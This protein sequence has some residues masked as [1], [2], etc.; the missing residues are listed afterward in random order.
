MRCSKTPKL[1]KE[2][3]RSSVI[4]DFEGEGKRKGST[5]PPLPHMVGIFHP[6]KTGKS[7]KYEWVALRENWRPAVNGSI[8]M[9]NKAR[10]SDLEEVFL[11]IAESVTQSQGRIIHWSQHESD[12]LQAFLK[13]ATWKM[14]EPF[15]FNARIPAKRYARR[16]KIF[17]GSGEVLGKTLEEFF[18]ALYR[19]RNPFPPL[20]RGAAATCRL[21]DKACGSRKRWRNFTEAE[22]GYVSEL[23]EYN[24]GDCKTT[25]LITLKTVNAALS[26]LLS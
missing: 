18:D 16:R 7:G 20:P 24:K 11:G 15:L 13:P 5:S 22:M 21:I 26:R 8:G 3:L 10:L 4:I 23:I 14:V 17:E 12:I 1:S 9:S 25:F 19:K 2:Q 6:N